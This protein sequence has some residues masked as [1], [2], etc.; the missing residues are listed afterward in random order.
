MRR[1]TLAVSVLALLLGAYAAGLTTVRTFWPVQSRPGPVGVC[2][3]TKMDGDANWVT[4]VST[5]GY[6]GQAIWCADGNYTS[7]IPGDRRGA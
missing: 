6:D 3:A 2:V 7:A 5:P 1:V 4:D